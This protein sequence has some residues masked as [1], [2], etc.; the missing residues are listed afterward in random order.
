[1]NA[2]QFSAL[3]YYIDCRID[4]KVNGR[5]GNDTLYESSASYKAE[6]ELYKSFGIEQ[7]EE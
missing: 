3:L 1:M 6:E 5:L 7:K 4:E 2:E